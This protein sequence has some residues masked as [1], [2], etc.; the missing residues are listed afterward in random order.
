MERRYS[1]QFISRHR[2]TH[3]ISGFTLVEVLVVAPVILLTIAAFIGIIITLTGEALV[4]R[5]SNALTYDT[6]EALN[7]MEEDVR[8]SGAFLSVNKWVIPSPYGYNN[9]TQGFTNASSTTGTMLILN[10]SATYKDYAGSRFPVWRANQPNP[11]TA[12]NVSQNSTMPINIVYFIK[13]GTL[14]RRTL[15]PPFYGD[16]CTTPTQIATCHPSVTSGCQT[17]DTRVL[18]DVSSLDIQYFSTASAS[19]PSANASNPSQTDSN[20]Q[21]ALNSTTTALITLTAGK[22]VAG[23][24]VTYSGTVRAT[25]AGSFLND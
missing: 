17:R 1:M 19:S 15:T 3:T 21:T 18:D 16:A 8:M 20:R 23:R 10:T 12:G 4:A 7:M 22:S 2:S 25:R 5:S 13:D 14:F 24:D 11:C 9:A 6:Q